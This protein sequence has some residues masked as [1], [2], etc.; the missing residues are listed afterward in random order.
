MQYK[1]SLS[2]H[3]WYDVYLDALMQC[4]MQVATLIQSVII[5]TDL[6]L[7]RVRDAILNI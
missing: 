1:L 3:L 5:S 2:K 4:R 7:Q 6:P